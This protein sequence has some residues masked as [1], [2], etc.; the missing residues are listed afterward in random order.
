MFDKAL[1]EKGVISALKEGGKK[2]E[3]E[4]KFRENYVTKPLIIP[5]ILLWELGENLAAGDEV[6]F[7][8]LPDYTG[9]ILHRFDN[10]GGKVFPWKTRSLVDF[11]SDDVS[12]K[13]HVHPGVVAGT[14]KTDEPE[15]G[16][17]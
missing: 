11:I 12:G 6:L 13:R 17:T 5:W 16:A 3:V 1:V 15:G 10:E 4:S 8:E 9:M 7:V 14:D 2:A